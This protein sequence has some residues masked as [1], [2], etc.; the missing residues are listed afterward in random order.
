MPNRYQI[1]FIASFLLTFAVLYAAS[2]YIGGKLKAAGYDITE[3]IL[4]GLPRNTSMSADNPPMSFDFVAQLQ[5]GGYLQLAALLL[6][7]LSS[8]FIYTKFSPKSAFAFLF[9]QNGLKKQNF[10]G[11]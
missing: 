8:Y 2:T 4:I 5:Q 7:A 11:L 10:D 9:V 3:L 6:A 1:A